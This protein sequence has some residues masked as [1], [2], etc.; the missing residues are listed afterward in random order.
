MITNKSNDSCG[1][2]PMSCS[3]AD[4]KYLKMNE[5]EN[6]QKRNELISS[7]VSNVCFAT[8]VLSI[9]LELRI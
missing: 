5:T 2:S 4:V 7:N 9:K 8:N 1:C 6:T 3:V